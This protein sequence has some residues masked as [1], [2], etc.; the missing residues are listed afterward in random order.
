[1]ANREELLAHLTT[2]VFFSTELPAGDEGVDEISMAFQYLTESCGD[3]LRHVELAD[4]SLWDDLHSSM[5][6]SRKLYIG[7]I[8]QETKTVS[9]MS[10]LKSG[11]EL[12]SSLS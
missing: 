5:L 10:S 9:Q 1:M 2:N 4:V 12:T 6:R 3:F 7:D 11:R 8:V